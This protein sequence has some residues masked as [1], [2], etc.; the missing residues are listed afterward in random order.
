MTDIHTHI[1]FG[2]DDGA[3]NTEDSVKLLEAEARKA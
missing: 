2:M 1:L 3:K